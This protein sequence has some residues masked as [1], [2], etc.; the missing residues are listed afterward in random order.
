MERPKLELGRT[1]D[2]TFQGAN[3]IDV[4][5]L[6]ACGFPICKKFNA[7]EGILYSSILKP[8]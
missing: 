8:H 1:P 5:L 2:F 6:R 3:V 4:K 7:D